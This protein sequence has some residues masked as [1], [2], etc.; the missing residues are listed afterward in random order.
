MNTPEENPNTANPGGKLSIL[1]FILLVLLVA[2]IAGFL[3]LKDH[4]IDITR[5]SV[6]DLLQ[7]KGLPVAADVGE[8]AVE[9]KYDAKDYPVF[10]IYK[11][12]IVR[13]TKN[14]IAYL[15]KNGEEQWEY[16]LSVSDPLVRV[17]GAELLVADRVSK[18]VNVFDGKSLKW[19]KK[20]DGNILNADINDNGDVAVVH[21]AK[22]YSGAVTVFSP[23]GVDRFT[24]YIAERLI[25]SARMSPSGKQMLINTV[26]TSGINA[27]TLI[28]FA[29]IS[30]KVLP[31]K[32]NVDNT[33]F[34][35]IRYI[36]DEYTLASSD[37]LVVCYGPD[38]KEKWRQEYPKGKVASIAASS[39]KYAVAAVNIEGK[40]PLDGGSGGEIQIFNL[41]G[42]KTDTY[43]VDRQ[44]KNIE[45][46]GNV[47][48]VNTGSE[49]YFINTGA[50]LLKKYTSMSEIDRVLFFS[51]QEAAVITKG[52]IVII[53]L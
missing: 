9:I 20:L 26:D 1:A 3:Y 12:Y 21:E 4:N 10:S 34:P 24:S 36:N 31:D 32:I 33:I 48:A 23:M 17:G 41:K 6:K 46:C 15:N 2:G 16:N 11:D 40:L 51:K 22:G 42:Q 5:I 8:G 35:S 25:L 45:A 49:A 43:S 37:S 7:G 53:K 52:S 47:I 30:G 28:E 19:S 39:E 29:D 13:C 18:E 44:V 50:Q 38:K 14:S 27:A